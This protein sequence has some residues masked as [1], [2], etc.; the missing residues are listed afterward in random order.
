MEHLTYDVDGADVISAVS[1][2]WARFA[3]ENVAP[4]LGHDVVGHSLWGF[5]SDLTTRRVYRDL[6]ARAK[7]GEVVTFSFRCDSPCLRRFMRMTMTATDEGGVRF[8]SLTLRT[9]PR[10]APALMPIDPVESETHLPSCSWCKR[11]AVGHRWEEVEM[12]VEHL[13]ALGGGPMPTLTQA[14][15]PECIE[16]VMKESDLR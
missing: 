15:C 14:M 3:A 2:S 9:E 4:Q 8:D 12:A 13:G 5:I 11:V 10:V 1:D 7:C 6:M 16:R